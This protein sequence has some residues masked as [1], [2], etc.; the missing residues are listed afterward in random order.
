[1]AADFDEPGSP[2]SQPGM[3]EILGFGGSDTHRIIDHTPTVVLRIVAAFYRRG[4]VFRAACVTV[5]G[6][7]A[8][9]GGGAVIEKLHDKSFP[10]PLIEAPSL[11]DISPPIQPYPPTASRH[12]PDARQPA[13]S[14][15]ERVDGIPHAYTPP[16]SAGVAPV[17]DGRHR[18]ATADTLPALP[19]PLATPGDHL[20]ATGPT[21]ILHANASLGGFLDAH[22]TFVV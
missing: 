1:M 7:V 2:E 8:V 16:S 14:P 13:Q 17:A 21:V 22:L 18:R 5:A 20:P 9:A 15:A 11:F 3:R 4:P 12:R 6:S 10:E 19:L